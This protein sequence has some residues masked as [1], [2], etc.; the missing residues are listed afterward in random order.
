MTLKGPRP[1]IIFSPLVWIGFVNVL[2]VTTMI[3]FSFKVIFFLIRRK[4]LLR[5]S[6]IPQLVKNLTA[7]QETPVQF[8]GLEDPREKGEITHF[9]ILGLPWLLSW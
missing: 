3:R 6:L 4:K 9:S 8:L 5:V 7:M 2:D 1:C